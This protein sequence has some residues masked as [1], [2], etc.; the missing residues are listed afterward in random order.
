MIFAMQKKWETFFL[1][2]FRL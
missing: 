2:W 1:G